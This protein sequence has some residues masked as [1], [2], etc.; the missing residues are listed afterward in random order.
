MDRFASIERLIGMIR[1]DISAIKIDLAIHIYRTDLSEQRLKVE[2]DRLEKMEELLEVALLP[3]K[4]AKFS[5]KILAVVATLV[6]IA[7]AVYNMVGK[8]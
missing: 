1:E 3:I 2:S 4:W 6:A 8:N 5:I 7:A